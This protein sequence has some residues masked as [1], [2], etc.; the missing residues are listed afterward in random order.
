MGEGVNV[1]TG[2]LAGAGGKPS[3]DIAMMHGT[4]NHLLQ[5]G[6]RMPSPSTAPPLPNP[7]L[8]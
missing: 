7:S 5:S 1:G 8:H 6:L 2:T 4:D 3:R